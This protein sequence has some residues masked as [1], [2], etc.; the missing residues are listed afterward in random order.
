[1]ISLTSLARREYDARRPRT[2]SELAAAKPAT[3]H[4]FRIILWGCDLLFALT[5]FGY[6]M[7]HL[8][9]PVA[10]LLFGGLMIG[11]ELFVAIVPARRRTLQLH[12][13]IAR[14]M[15][16]GMLGL[17]YT[18]FVVCSG[19][20]ATVEMLLAGIMS[21]LA[22]MALINRSRFCFTSCRSSISRTSPLSSRPSPPTRESRP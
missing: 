10:I 15:A 21:L 16:A 7:P 3:L 5:V 1:M 9:Q 8:A 4:R 11:G 17:A 22:I 12:E 13:T 18:F 19:L 2:L 14:I 20:A 6:L